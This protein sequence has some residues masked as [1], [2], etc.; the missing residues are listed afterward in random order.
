[1]DVIWRENYKDGEERL[2]QMVSK[3]GTLKMD[4]CMDMGSVTKTISIVL[5]N[6]FMEILPSPVILRREAMSVR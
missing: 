5:A 4:N 1:M 2:T 6:L 3:K